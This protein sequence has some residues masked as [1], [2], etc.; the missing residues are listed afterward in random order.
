MNPSNPK[1]IA[2]GAVSYLNAQPLLEVIPF[3]IL[4]EVPSKLLSIFNTGVVDAALLSVY[5]ILQMVEPEVVDG[6]A[7]GCR[8][9]VYSVILAYEGELK[10]IKEI[11]LDPASH[12]ANNLLKIIL[13]EF[14]DLHPWY[15]TTNSSS[16]SAGAQLT[17]SPLQESLSRPVSSIDNTNFNQRTNQPPTSNLQPITT[18]RPVGRIDTPRL[19]IGDPAIVFRQSAPCAIRHF[20]KLAYADEVQGVD[21]AQKLSV[22]KLLDT[23]S[24]GATK[25]FAA[26]V[27]LGKVSIL[28]LGEEW[29]NFTKL[30]FIF[31]M[32]CLNK[33][34]AHKKH[35]TEILKSAKEE[36]LLHR[37]AIA[38]AQSDPKLALHYLTES[39][40]YDL[41]QEER[42]G[43]ELFRFLLRKYK[44]LDCSEGM[45][46]YC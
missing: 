26:E 14:Y 9:P 29:Y 28:D 43:L 13:A 33:N 6:V 32:W 7:I 41:G 46:K 24:P 19:I 17:L 25:Q 20:S 10:D 45:M 3:P 42:R 36:G 12:T 35:L 18:I 27:E 30:P 4:K 23:S 1:E 44:L 2:L 15:I 37:E 5:D 31:A 21:G 16:L 22:Q 40:R 11:L 34:S 38:A 8:G 39:I